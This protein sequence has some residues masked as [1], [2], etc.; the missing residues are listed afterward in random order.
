METSQNVLLAA[1]AAAQEVQAPGPQNWIRLALAQSRSAP[2]VTYKVAARVEQNKVV[3]G[4]SCPDWVYRRKAAGT[5]C[6]HLQAICTDRPRDLSALHSYP[7]AGATLTPGGRVFVQ[8]LN[9]VSRV[10]GEV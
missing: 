9:M 10:R 7:E 4:C 1:F 3:L 2:G 6:K 5:K 8:V